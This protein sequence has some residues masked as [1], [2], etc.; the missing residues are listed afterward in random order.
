MLHRMTKAAIASIVLAILSLLASCQ[1]AAVLA[2]PPTMAASQPEKM[3][4]TSPAPVSPPSTNPASTAGSPVY[5]ACS[6]PATVHLDALNLADHPTDW[7]AEQ[8][9][10]DFDDPA[11]P[12]INTNSSK[13]IKL[14][15]SLHGPVP[16]PHRTVFFAPDGNDI[17]PGTDPNHP[18]QSAN[19]AI[20]L[21]AD[22]TEFRF[23]R[24]SV[25]T[26][27]PEF[28]MKQ[29]VTHSRPHR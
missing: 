25:Y 28:S 8:F 7:L 9:A 5:T 12:T 24:G 10:W 20:K 6:S 13:G 16:P 21:L 19:A 2:N 14:N 1:P 11:E 29:I 18:L 3:F 22:H 27:E 17:N 15:N 26:F 4:S 23:R